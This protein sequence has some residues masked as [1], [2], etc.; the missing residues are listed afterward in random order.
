MGSR[1][2]PTM[3]ELVLNPN[4]YTLDVRTKWLIYGCRKRARVCNRKLYIKCVAGTV[5]S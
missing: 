3:F 5:R 1:S 4:S 2:I